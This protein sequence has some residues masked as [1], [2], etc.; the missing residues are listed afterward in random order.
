MRI[1]R[2]FDTGQA[3][4]AA[5]II[6]ENVPGVNSDPDPGRVKVCLANRAGFGIMEDVEKTGRSL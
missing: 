4:P 6:P 1:L 3:V 2:C 5:I